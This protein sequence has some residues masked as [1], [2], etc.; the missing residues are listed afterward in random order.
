MRYISEFIHISKI[1]LYSIITTV[2]GNKIYKYNDNIVNVLNNILKN[3]NMNM[4]TVEQENF[5]KQFFEEANKVTTNESPYINTE[6]YNNM[7][8]KFKDLDIYLGG[9]V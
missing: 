7:E 5:Y 1:K 2:T 3:N 8:Q 6:L 9:I 4:C